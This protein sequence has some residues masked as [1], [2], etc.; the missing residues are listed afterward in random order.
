MISVQKRPFIPG[1]LSYYV[2][3]VNYM[4]SGIY[5]EIFF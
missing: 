1:K 2:E 4:T 3:F 5:F